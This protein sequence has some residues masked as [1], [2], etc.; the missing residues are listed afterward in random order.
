MNAIRPIPN[1]GKHVK[2]DYKYNA[3]QRTFLGKADYIVLD[4]HHRNERILTVGKQKIQTETF[5]K[6][7][8]NGLSFKITEFTPL[9]SKNKTPKYRY[10][11]A[12]NPT[13]KEPNKPLGKQIWNE[14]TK[15]WEVVKLK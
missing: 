2:I 8:N 15:K 11:Q 9:N 14:E 3:F 5:Y 4:K 7:D 12:V 10:Y 13:T 6:N 1:V